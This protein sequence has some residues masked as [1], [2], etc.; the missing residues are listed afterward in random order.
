MGSYFGYAV[1]TT[2]INSDG[3]V[4]ASCLSLSVSFTLSFSIISCRIYI[5]CHQQLITGVDVS[6][7]QLNKSVFLSTGW[8]TC[9]WELPCSWSEA[10]MAAW[11]RWAAS[12]FTYSEA[13]W[14]WSS[15]HLTWQAP[16]CLGDLAAPLHHWEIWTRTGSM[17]RMGDCRRG[18]RGKEENK[19]IYKGR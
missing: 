3:W 6:A 14:T 5:W 10:P 17:V 4:E 2:D 1:A 11:K 13:P 8:P 15:A 16:R 9:W 18:T 12:T 7:P 19:I